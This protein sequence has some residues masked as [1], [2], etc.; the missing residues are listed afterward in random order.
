MKPIRPT[1]LRGNWATLLLPIRPD[2]SID[3]ELLGAEISHFGAAGASGIYSN[4]TAGEFYTQT[5]E[6]FDRVNRMLA[7]GCERLRIPFQIGASQMSPQLSLERVRRARAWQPSGFQVILPDW[8]PPTMEDIH[9]FLELMAASADPI[10]L[11]VYNPPHAKRRLVPSEWVEIVERH[12][13]VVGIK[14]ADGDADWYE[15]MRPVLDKVAVFIPGHHLATG[16]SRGA[17]GAY[18]NVACLSPR[19][20]QRWYELCLSDSAEGLKLEEKI[21][22]FISEEVMP[23]INV[24]KLPNMGADKLLAVGGGWLPGMTTRLRWPYEGATEA[25]AIRIGAAARLALPEL[26]GED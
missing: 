3:Y 1:E 22:R 16:L 7:E 6:E 19:G 10:P 4:G 21:I 26:F 13:G 15:A 9:R 14:V 18:S 11:V 23:L 24:K 17:Q 20:A 8:Y 2:Q 5:E 25:E 12:P